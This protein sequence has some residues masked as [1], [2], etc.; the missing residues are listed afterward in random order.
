V[1]ATTHPLR[2]PPSYDHAVRRGVLP[3]DVSGRLWTDGAPL[4]LYSLLSFLYFGL[5]PLAHGSSY[6]GSG[7]DPQIFI[8]SFA[9]WPHALLH[10]ENPVVSHAIWAPTGVDLAW[11]TT[12]PGLALLFAP[13]TLAAGATASY[14]VAAVLAPAVSAWTA[15]L[16]CRR[17]T[18][19]AWP[20]LVGGYLFGFSSYMLGQEQGHL[21]MTAV[22]LV[23][24]AAL[25][26]LRYLDGELD[27][28]GLVVRLGPL[29][30]F[31]LLLSTE[32]LFT[33]SLAIASSLVLVFAFV[34]ERRRRLAT[35]VLPI[36]G[37]YGVAV[38]LT[39]PVVYYLVTDFQGQAFHPSQDFRADLLNFVV[40]TRFALVGYHWADSIASHFP[41]NDSER[42]A[43]LGVPALLAVVLHA[44]ERRRSR[45]TYFLVAAFLLAVLA[46]LGATLTVD[47]ARVAPLP[48]EHV[49]YLP[50]FDN[51]LV[52]RLALYASLAVA[53]MVALWLA[54]PRHRGLRVAV[55]VL[56]V[57]AIAPNVASSDWS[58][59]FHLPRFFTAAAYRQCLAPGAIILPVPVS[60][61]GSANLWQV[62]RDFRFRMAG[63][64]LS[65]T[66]PPPFMAPPGIEHIALGAPPGS[67][68]AVRR[69]LAAK[70]VSV[71]VL[72]AGAGEP[73]P[74]TLDRIARPHRVGGVVLYRVG[75]GAAGRRIRVTCRDPSRRGH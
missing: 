7:G 60:A 66:P 44:W 43:Y 26:V 33:L 6:I 31:Q 1:T 3:V 47:G 49:G 40:P 16:L 2:M 56:A 61:G 63:G 17:V 14:D 9:W 42:D 5:R 11:T 54:S 53:V 65:S 55:A 67:V 37:S 75:G 70:H 30:A 34:P 73:W 29:L 10:G 24:L 12:V 4:V 64:Y 8:W 19:R 38:V 15:Y 32:L 36:A 27:D 28:R 39:A 25:L 35:A 71:V 45:G 48:W 68:A 69:Y 62:E 21:H 72:D 46:S 22:F 20:A 52:P 74:S 58:T 18:R 13:L 41:G 57:A 51:V 23:P 50:L 59:P